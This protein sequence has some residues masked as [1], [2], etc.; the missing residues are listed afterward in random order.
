[1]STSKGT[2]LVAALALS[3]P[4]AA[5]AATYEINPAHSAASFAVK[6][7]MVSTVRGEFGKLTGFATID[8]ADLKKSQIE[9][10]ID[11]TTISTRVDKRDAH[12]KGPDFF[13]VAKYPSITFK[14]TNVKRVAPG[15]Y[16]VTGDLT[17]HG[18]T[19]AVV[20]DVDSPAKEL[21][22]PMGQIDRGAT[23]TTKLNRKDFGLNWNKALEAG[24]V[25]VGDQVDVTIDMELNR[26]DA[27]SA[28][29]AATK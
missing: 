6:H 8:D 4:A 22:D 2:F 1:M 13:D 20:F 5:S 15:K 9:A 14:S 17:M 24:G 16:K 27:A 25:L 12:L 10:T 11:A 18:V 19:K 26:K 23:A 21:K 28:T 7:M 29:A 3:L